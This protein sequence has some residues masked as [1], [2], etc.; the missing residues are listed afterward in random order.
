[1]TYEELG[2]Y[3]IDHTD[4]GCFIVVLHQKYDY[5]SDYEYRRCVEYFVHSSKDNIEYD[6]DFNE[7]EQCIV[8]DGIFDLDD[9]EIN[10]NELILKGAIKHE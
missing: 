7:G 1:M 5:E 8:V 9:A 3:L 6:F 2:D 10:G 4:V